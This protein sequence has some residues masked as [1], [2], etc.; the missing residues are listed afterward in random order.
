MAKIHR[1]AALK[2]QDHPGIVSATAAQQGTLLIQISQLFR[3]RRAGPKRNGAGM[4][5]GVGNLAATEDLQQFH[6]G[7]GVAG[8]SGCTV[9]DTGGKDGPIYKGDDLLRLIVQLNLCAAAAEFSTAMSGA[10]A[11]EMFQA[12]VRE[13]PGYGSKTQD[14]PI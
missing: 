11:K 6:R 2:E 8:S 5:A 3:H 7:A 4:V 10:C 12:C 14:V 1:L 13:P 9:A